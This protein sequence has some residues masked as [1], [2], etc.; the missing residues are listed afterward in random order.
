[1]AHCSCWGLLL[2]PMLIV[3]MIVL[4]IVHI[5]NTR[6]EYSAAK[7]GGCPSVVAFFNLAPMSPCYGSRCTRAQCQ[8]DC[9]RTSACAG[10]EFDAYDQAID[11]SGYCF[12][13]SKQCP[14]PLN[15]N[16][17]DYRTRWTY[18]KTRMTFKDD[19]EITFQSI[20]SKQILKGGLTGPA[21]PVRSPAIH[22]PSRWSWRSLCQT[23]LFFFLFTFPF[24][25]NRCFFILMLGSS[26]KKESKHFAKVSSSLMSANAGSGSSAGVVVGG[27]GGG[28]G[29]STPKPSKKVLELPDFV[30]IHGGCPSANAFLPMTKNFV[31]SG[32]RCQKVDCATACLSSSVCI[33]FEFDA[34]DQ[35]QLSSVGYCWLLKATCQAKLSTYG[36]DFASR[37][38]YLRRWDEKIDTSPDSK[39]SSLV[40]SI[41]QA[42][43]R[44]QAKPLSAAVK[45][46]SLSSSS[47]LSKVVQ[48]QTQSR[49]PLSSISYDKLK[50]QSKPAMKHEMPLAR[51]FADIKK[52]SLGKSKWRYPS[53]SDGAID[54]TISNQPLVPKMQFVHGWNLQRKSFNFISIISIIIIL[55]LLL[56]FF[57]Y[58]A[59]HDA[60]RRLHFF[61]RWWGFGL[62][63]NDWKGRQWFDNNNNVDNINDNNGGTFVK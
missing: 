9:D 10:Y 61:T 56:L 42:P 4:I 60:N 12:M 41:G 39:A 51:S 43:P 29:D 35:S 55:C 54:M 23:P 63:A 48:G 59:L 36:E 52:L 18:M 1:M 7:Q 16:G 17:E 45:P 26:G 37:W 32:S 44:S 11:R 33:G 53:S 50:Y 34:W 19:F 20:N 15:V 30:S 25:L 57:I 8:A 49:K 38:T 13:L 62:F 27:G 24:F 31:C 40:I 46:S 28:G 21:T 22:K 3:M 2:H 58:R 14:Q 6:A 5:P 47:L